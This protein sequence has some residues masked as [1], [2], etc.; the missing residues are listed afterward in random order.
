[1]LPYAPTAWYVPPIVKEGHEIR[2]TRHLYK[3]KPLRSLEE[4]RSA[5]LALQW[6][7]AGLLGE[8]VDGLAADGGSKNDAWGK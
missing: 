4:I 1:M 5:I 8:I 7:T 6:K 3:P 2:F